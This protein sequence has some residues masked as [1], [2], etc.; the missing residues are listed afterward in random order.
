MKARE[1]AAGRM[2]PAAAAAP[3]RR[4]HAPAGLKK[5]IR[6]RPKGPDL[7]YG[8]LA[9]NVTGRGEYAALLSGADG[10]TFYSI[11]ESSYIDR[12]YLPGEAEE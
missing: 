5:R 11:S 8:F 7:F 9:D 10:T 6:R 2:L 1:H 12:H 4:E 3:R